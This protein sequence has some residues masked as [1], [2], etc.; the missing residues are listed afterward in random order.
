MKKVFLAFAIISVST[1]FVQAQTAILYNEDNS[2]TVDAGAVVFVDG[3]VVN[4]T[5]GRIFNSGDIYLTGD[6]DNANA[7]GCLDPVNGTVYLD[8]TTQDIM[9]TQTTTFNNLDCKTTGKKTLQI[10]TYVGGT[11]GVLSLR[12]S[13][14]DLNSNL[15]RVTNPATG[16]IT[17]NTGYIISETDPLA[18]YGTVQWDLNTAAAGSNYT[19]PFGTVSGGYI[20]FLF[21]VTTAGAGA[22]GNM[23]VST[24]PTSV[25][26]SPNNRPLPSLVGNLDDPS[27]SAEAGPLCADRF[28]IIDANNY[29]TNP[30]ADIAF[31]YRENE[32]DGTSGSTNT[33]VEDSLRAWRWTG[34]QWQNPPV[35][36]DNPTGNLVTVTGVN[37]FSPW[38]LLGVEPPPPPPCGDFFLPTAFSPNGDNKNDYFRPRSI[39][40][41]SLELKIYNRWGNL[42]FETTDVNTKGWDGSTIKGGKEA[43]QEVFVYQVIAT[44]NDGKVHDLKGNVTL[45]R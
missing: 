36:T 40:I 6:W 32:W 21:N 41:K 3:D 9:G 1:C 12:D 19:Y 7:A 23:A 10:T 27:T 17:R 24:Y 5:T 28:W 22:S 30:T 15:L 20:P 16:A 44:M 31:T 42:V 25:A 38:T 4:A 34:A 8:G 13:P 26:A 2:F 33:I 29:A 39:C 45:M 35:G 11:S 43:N 37:T 18:G 14:F